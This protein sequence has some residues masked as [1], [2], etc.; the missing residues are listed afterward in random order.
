MGSLNNVKRIRKELN[1]TVREL[2]TR[3]D[4]SHSTITSLE[5]GLSTPNHITML[6]LCR[7]L[8]KE[9]SEVFETDWKVLDSY[10]GRNND[11]D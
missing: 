1:M 3:C 2:A 11:Q 6:L 5:N 7:G 8:N 10:L 4:L 9:F